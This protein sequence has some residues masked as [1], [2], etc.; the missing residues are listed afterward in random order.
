MQGLTAALAYQS[1]CSQITDQHYKCRCDAV[2]RPVAAL[3]SQ[4][5]YDWVD[6]AFGEMRGKAPFYGHTNS[7]PE[8]MHLHTGL[9]FY[10]WIGIE[11]MRIITSPSSA[12]NKYCGIGAY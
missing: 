9:E 7:V 12:G 1:E 3:Q 11:F 5:L 4:R 6:T 10:Y 2:L 8:N